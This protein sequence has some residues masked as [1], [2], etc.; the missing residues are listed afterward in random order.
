MFEPQVAFGGGG[1]TVWAGVTSNDRTELV[2]LENQSMNA[3][4]YRDLCI[5][6]HVVPYAENYG[7]DFHYV[8]DN[9]RPHRA[10]IVNEVLRDHH[11]TRMIWPANSPD[12]NPIEPCGLS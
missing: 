11:I 4:R 5:L 3:V 9:A 7:P 1:V 6:P 10:A 8:D 12:L 2:I